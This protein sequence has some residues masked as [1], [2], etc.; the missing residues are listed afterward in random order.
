MLEKYLQDIGLNDKE[1][2]IYLSLLS[3]EHASVLD[4]AKRLK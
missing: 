1:A 3:V 4:L 2:A